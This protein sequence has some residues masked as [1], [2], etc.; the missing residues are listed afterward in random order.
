MRVAVLS[1]IHGF[2]PAFETVLAELDRTGPY[3]EIVVAGDLFEAG[4]CPDTVLE[5]LQARGYPAVMGNTDFE[6]MRASEQGDSEESTLYALDQIG[7]GGV[8]YI[9]ALPMSYRISPPGGNAPDDDLLVVHANPHNL[10]DR[11]DPA[12]GD[13]ELKELIGDVPCAAI[14]FGHY[15]VCF[16]HKIDGRL[17]LDVSAVGNPKDGDLRCKFGVLTWNEAQR[18]WDAELV[19]LPYPLDETET[20]MRESAMPHWEKAFKKLQRAKYKEQ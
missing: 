13:D 17:L 10:Y 5:L 14:A 19:K 6:I 16:R 11:L 2:S 4:P 15:H 20:L 9:A 12:Y 7:P 8:A 1:D 3:D 18:K